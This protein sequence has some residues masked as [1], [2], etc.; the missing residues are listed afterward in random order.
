LHADL[1]HR[2]ILH[3][4]D[5]QELSRK[6][7]KQDPQKQR[8]TKPKRRRHVY[9]RSGTIRLL[10]SKVLTSHRR[11]RRW[12]ARRGTRRRLSWDLSPQMF[13]RNTE[14]AR[15][16]QGPGRPMEPDA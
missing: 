1:N 10:C 12:R 14:R 15:H 6:E 3:S 7:K 16:A 8:S 9:R 5:R 2:R 11:R 4:E 13:E